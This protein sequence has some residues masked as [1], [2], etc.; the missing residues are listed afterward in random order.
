MKNLYKRIKQL[1]KKVAVLEGS[2]QAQHPIDLI[3]SLDGRAIAKTVT[4]Y[5]ISQVAQE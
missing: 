3:I 2:V 4:N 5:G 1:E